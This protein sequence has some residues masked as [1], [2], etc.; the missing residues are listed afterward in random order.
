[1]TI[2][3]DGTMP[4]PELKNNPE[5]NLT[6]IIS[7]LGASL[8][9]IATGLIKTHQDMSE[10]TNTEFAHNPDDYLQHAPNWHQYGIV[11]HSLEFA[12]AMNEVIPLYL[13]QWGIAEE[14]NKV[15]SEKIENVSKKE[16]LEV[17]SLLHDVGKFTARRFE[18]S[19]SHQ[20]SHHFDDH[21]AHSGDVVRNELSQQLIGSGLT[22]NHIEYIARCVELHFELGKT[23]RASKASVGYTMSFVFTPEF[24]EAAQEI[25]EANPDF[26]LEIGLQFIADNLSKSEVQARA[27]TDEQI[28]GQR[29][30][31][32]SEITKRGLN[33][34]IVN[35]ALQMPV[36]FAV[37]HAYLT[38]WAQSQAYR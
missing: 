3:T 16:L 7:H 27:G 23:R 11:T 2:N 12:R 32:L 15:L 19:D 20:S 10:P 31:L 24:H 29:D 33:P 6:E 18:I 34:T 36:N 14:A 26:G 4:T 25:I 21:E 22:H 8:P 28:E 17:A 38:Q 13:E 35:Q 9:S 37:A 1:M 5:V 30:E